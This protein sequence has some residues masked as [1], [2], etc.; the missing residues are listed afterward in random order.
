MRFLAAMVGFA[1]PLVILAQWQTLGGGLSNGP[2][3]MIYDSTA[4]R[5]LVGGQFNYAD[6][7]PVHGVAQWY[8]AWNALGT[9]VVPDA[10]A[11]PLGIELYHD[12]LYVGGFFNQMGPGPGTSR[13]AR[14]NGTD[15]ESIGGSGATGV[16]WGMRILNDELHV[17]GILDSVAGI[18]VH[19]WAIY[20]G[21]SWRTGDTVDFM[22]AP[23]GL[24]SIAQYQG[25]IYV[26]GNFN[27]ASG[28]NDIAKVTP[29]GWEPVGSGISCDPWVNDMVVFNGLLYVGGE[30][31]EFGNANGY[32]MAWDGTQW[33]DPFPQVEWTSQV[34]D[35]DIV[36]GKLMIAG[37]VRPVG[38][39]AYYGI[40]YYD[41]SDL[42]I[43]GGEP[44]FITEVTGH[45]DTVYCAFNYTLE[46]NPGGT[47]VNYI[48]S[49]DL[50]NATDTCFAIVQSVPGA[51]T[52]SNIAVFP[53]PAADQVQ[54]QLPVTSP[55]SRGHLNLF[56]PSGRLV[57]SS[58][59]V[60][61]VSGR[62]TLDVSGISP[63]AYVLSI[64]AGKETKATVIRLIIQ[65]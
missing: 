16:V 40:C 51:T 29:A 63:G 60:A 21:S 41:G 52:T 22:T 7:I 38:S 36:D 39:N 49:W 42:C 33:L 31:C 58:R 59:Y 12:T 46:G 26:G 18:P 25:E 64:S 45:G 50:N 4:M 57:Y 23:Q 24:S 47:V 15:W 27:T 19:N 44:R 13:L 55:N 2:R 61:D 37:Q 5:L 62:F 9:G 56:D 35:L 65:P 48:A 20:D 30:F 8:G 28:I 43:F 34:R 6:G 17:L 54:I 3:S 1:C 53:N 10:S 11:T 32:L 14:F